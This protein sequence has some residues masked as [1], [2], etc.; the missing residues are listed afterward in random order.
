[1]LADHRHALAERSVPA[2]EQRQMA[3][4]MGDEFRGKQIEELRSLIIRQT[5]NMDKVI[6]S[7]EQLARIVSSLEKRIIN[8][9]QKDLTSDSH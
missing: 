1:M 6:Q 3:E 4:T 2:R 9:E 8:L 5:A 7:L